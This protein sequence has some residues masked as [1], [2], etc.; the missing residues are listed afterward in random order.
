MRA[1]MINILQGVM[2]IHDHDFIHRDLKPQN[3][4]LSSIN[5]LKDEDFKLKI[6]DF[7]LSVQY[8][9]LNFE[10]IDEKA[11][12]LIYMA[13]EQALSKTYGKVRNLLF[14]VL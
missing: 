2:Y 7:G 3:I 8:K 14:K 12:T 10:D 11:G 4:L 5:S 9:A 6:V 13:P 1:I